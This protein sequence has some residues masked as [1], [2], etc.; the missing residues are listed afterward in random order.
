MMTIRQIAKSAANLVVFIGYLEA[1]EADPV[2]IL[3]FRS[4][5]QYY[6][7][8]KYQLHRTT[9][10]GDRRHCVP[11]GSNPRKGKSPLKLNTLPIDY[12]VKLHCGTATF[13]LIEAPGFEPCRLIGS[14]PS[15]R[16]GWVD[17]ASGFEPSPVRT[18]HADPDTASGIELR[19]M[20]ILNE[21][22]K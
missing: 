20:L 6:R 15:P 4:T 5:H 9:G 1:Q 13:H 14:Q 11:P 12:K 8:A 21:N 18:D 2:H 22:S 19:K 7:T 3:Q 17:S 10:D 16:M